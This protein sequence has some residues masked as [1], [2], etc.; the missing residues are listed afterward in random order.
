MKG[1]RERKEQ[2]SG[3][4][5]TLEAR[6]GSG[7]SIRT[8]SWL[9]APLLPYPEEAGSPD[10]KG[11]EGLRR[12]PAIVGPNQPPEVP[13]S[14]RRGDGRAGF[15]CSPGFFLHIWSWLHMLLARSSPHPP[16]PGRPCT[17]QHAPAIPAPHS[18]R[19]P[20][21]ERRAGTRHIHSS[22]HSHGCLAWDR[23]A[24]SGDQNRSRRDLF[25]TPRRPTENLLRRPHS[26]PSHPE[27]RGQI[28][29][30]QPL[31]LQE[32]GEGRL[33]QPGPAPPPPGAGTHP[34]PAAAIAR[35]ERPP[36]TT[37]PPKVLNTSPFNQ[38][39]KTLLQPQPD[40]G[41]T[42]RF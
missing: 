14:W 19:R 9:V 36:S 11:P 24:R 4:K 41:C 12:R 2:R 38:S 16:E 1:W 3:E 13:E 15:G 34:R 23:G 8:G 18:R 33:A 37:Q 42:S 22:F 29:V 7:D 6:R 30:F 40:P 20:A 26:R 21:G 27:T 35:T 17:T 25:P 32:K 5:G 28:H 39:R 10:R 31:F